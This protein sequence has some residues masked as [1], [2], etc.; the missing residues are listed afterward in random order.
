MSWD[1]F[2]DTASLIAEER[3]GVDSSIMSK[4][5]SN[6]YKESL[7][8]LLAAKFETI[9]SPNASTGLNSLENVSRN[10]TNENAMR[11]PSSKSMSW[12]GSSKIRGEIVLKMLLYFVEENPN[13]IAQDGWT[14]IIA[15]LL[16]A[17]SLGVLPPPLA[18]V[19]E[20]YEGLLPNT[21]IPIIL[22]LTHY[23]QCFLDGVSA[24]GSNPNRNMESNTTTKDL[25]AKKSVAIEKST[26]NDNKSAK[27][28]GFWGTIGSFIWSN[29]DDGK[30]SAQKDLQSELNA[31][32]YSES[33]ISLSG[34]HAIL[35]AKKPIPL[36]KDCSYRA[37]DGNCRNHRRIHEDPNSD[38]FSPVTSDEN[39]MLRLV[40][41]TSH[42][43]QI[44]FISWKI[45]KIT[46]FI[47]DAL[48]KYFQDV[49]AVI[50]THSSSRT[51]NDPA[52]RQRNDGTAT[53]IR[54]NDSKTTESHD[55]NSGP[56][57]LNE[58]H[59][60]EVT[61]VHAQRDAVMLL[62]WMMTILITSPTLSKSLWQRLEKSKSHKDYYMN[63]NLQL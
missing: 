46:Y 42:I 53:M 48:I 56:D 54:N 16:Y 61:L 38:S 43:D 20:G 23:G 33:V 47:F 45:E 28:T 19:R 21:K 3:D 31:G 41:L 40:L 11:V 22:P 29:A 24:I 50:I 27:A 35:L 10:M 30:T 14:A 12:I 32:K 26:T 37:I 51:I 62:E 57:S 49:L 44:I 63:I 15:V 4:Y 7:E 34:L 52:S 59:I 6:I 60:I 9:V 5:S 36:M 17:R 8:Q 39:D 55:P 18:F 25:I 1:D 13:M 58:N 2:Y